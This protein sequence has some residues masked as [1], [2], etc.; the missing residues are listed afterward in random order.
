MS[1]YE[2]SLKESAERRAARQKIIDTAN[3]HRA[4]PAIKAYSM[5]SLQRAVSSVRSR[6]LVDDKTLVAAGFHPVKDDD[7]T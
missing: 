3:R 2:M 5:Q 4:D 7:E 6:G 1:A